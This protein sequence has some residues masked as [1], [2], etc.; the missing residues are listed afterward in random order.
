LTVQFHMQTH[1]LWR[2]HKRLEMVPTK[3]P[4]PIFGHTWLFLGPRNRFLANLKQIMNENEQLFSVWL[5]PVPI[6]CVSQPRHLEVIL[7]STTNIK[8]P[9]QYQ[10]VESWLGTGLLTSTGQKWHS[11]RKMLTPT[12]H[13][14]ILD[15]FL[16]V[17][18]EKGK[19][20][21][22]KL[23]KNV[24][25]ASVDIFKY[26]TMCTLDVIC[27]TAMGTEVNAQDQ[28]NQSE[29]VKSVLEISE[30]LMTRMFT[31]WLFPDILYD[32]SPSGRRAKKLLKILHNFTDKVIKERKQK[33]KLE[34]TNERDDEDGI[35]EKKKL[36]FLDLLLETS[37]NGDT[38]TDE[39][40][41]EEVDTFMFE[42]HDTTAA[43]I[44]WVL[45]N[46]ATYP[47][48]QDKVYEELESIF[49][50]SDRMPTMKDLN[51]MKYLDRVMKESQ[52]MYPSVPIIGRAITKDIVMD[53][54]KLQAPFDVMLL[55]TV[56]HRLPEYY[57]E[58]DKFNP[59]NFLP[60]RAAARHPYAYIPFSAGPRNCIG[61]K[62]ALLEE[63]TII[64]YILRNYKLEATADIPVGLPDLI[65]RPENGKLLVRT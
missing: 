28:E 59:D 9:F 65:L 8:K 31:P 25:C 56:T 53:D 26:V 4:N 2:T 7:A 62:F 20:L 3:K 57:P 27:E 23:E 1:H 6:V 22:K 40:I 34:R 49:Q 54:M 42:G 30:L 5:G 13:F 55:I 63:K 50:G 24:G 21:V 43:G 19:V 33:Y 47:D 45:Q 48:I 14:K 16:E 32:L 36:T 38:L 64:T 35:G 51:E 39:E 61:Q 37:E 11:H 41:R 58:P 29:Y 10:F 60:E 18:A 12:F 17:F 15:H 44:S 46:L 52:R